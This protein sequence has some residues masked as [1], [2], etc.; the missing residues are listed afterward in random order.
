[1]RT[2]ISRSIPFSEVLN[3][4][5]T[6]METT[7]S[8]SC[9]EYNLVIPQKYGS[10]TIKGINFQEGIGAI[11]YDCSFNENTE[12]QFIIN[13]V[14]PLKFL[15][16]E[17]GEFRHHFAQEQKNHHV[18]ALENIIVASA[19][20][21][22]HILNF[23]AGVRT[24]I[25]SIEI[26]RK[27]FLESMACEIENL[28]STLQDLFEDVNAENMFYYHGSYSLKMAN[29]FSQINSFRGNGFYRNIFLHG[30]AYNLLA[31]QILEYHDALE[32]EDNRSVLLTRE[33][34]LVKEAV[35]IIE[36]NIL[37]FGGVHELAERVRLNPTKLQ[38]GFKE[39]Y[40][41]TVNGFVQEKRLDLAYDLIRSSDLS[42]SEIAYQ[43]GLSS[44]SYFSKIFKDRYGLTPSEIRGKSRSEEDK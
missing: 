42:F 18:D 5:A 1:M 12:I 29:L 17:K 9:E 14:Q 30:N 23:K 39:I 8:K 19:R 13:Q 28:D 43:V 22:G 6:A 35:D 36:N 4:L 33:L 11:F 41:L 31:V 44:K 25:N 38:E 26:D 24:I 21:E 7:Y 37:D 32:A 16:C 10:G 3:D 15:F 2:I 27:R 34:K 20:H 40:G